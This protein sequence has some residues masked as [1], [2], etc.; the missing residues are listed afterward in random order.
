VEQALA[1]VGVAERR[2]VEA[3]FDEAKAAL[4]VALDKPI[5]VTA[6]SQG[7][8]RPPV[9]VA[10]GAMHA[11][12]SSASGDGQACVRSASGAPAS[13]L[14]LPSDFLKRAIAASFPLACAVG[15]PTDRPAFEVV[16][17]CERPRLAHRSRR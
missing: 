7:D 10:P 13:L 14:L 5:Q 1:N 9:V 2:S 4:L 6:V 16:W 11:L 3:H 12:G 17:V 15:D 8:A